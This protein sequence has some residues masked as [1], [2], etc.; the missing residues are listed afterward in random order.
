MFEPKQL[1]EGK[2][3]IHQ[4]RDE[5]LHV[6]HTS[7]MPGCY[8]ES[9]IGTQ[10]FVGH[11]VEV[12]CQPADL[13]RVIYIQKNGQNRII[14][15]LNQTQQIVHLHPLNLIFSKWSYLHH[16]I[17][18]SLKIFVFLFVL[19]FVFFSITS[20]AEDQSHLITTILDTFMFSIYGMLLLLVGCIIPI[21]LPY[22]YLRRY[23]TIK[24]LKMLELDADQIL[25]MEIMN[26]Q[27]RIYHLQRPHS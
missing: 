10:N 8:F 14:A 18:N 3:F 22:C 9:L 16:V 23:K 20:Y 6:F 12:H 17:P 7:Y 11:F 21:R 5:L 26:P 24:L 25:Q 1:I 4:S 19:L 15:M 2:I 13:I 27:S